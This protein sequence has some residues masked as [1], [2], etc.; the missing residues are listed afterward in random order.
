MVLVHQRPLAVQVVHRGHNAAYHLE[1]LRLLHQIVAVHFEELEVEISDGREGAALDQDNLGQ[2]RGRVLQL[3][4]RN[5][6]DID[7]V[8]ATAVRGSDYFEAHGAGLA[9]RRS[10]RVRKGS[11]EACGTEH[12]CRGRAK[13][14]GLS[15]GKASRASTQG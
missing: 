7:L 14:A 6:L 11:G 1:L 9:R 3:V 5:I 15:E 10:A 4:Q 13:Q 12:D 2:V 8:A